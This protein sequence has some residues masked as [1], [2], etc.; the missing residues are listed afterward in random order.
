VKNSVFTTFFESLH[1]PWVAGSSP[2]FATYS[3]ANVF[4]GG[5]SGLQLV[6]SECQK[7]DRVPVLPLFA[8]PFAAVNFSLPLTQI[9]MFANISHRLIRLL[10]DMESQFNEV[11][12]FEGNFSGAS[13]VS[14][15]TSCTQLPTK[16]KMDS[17][18]RI[19]D[20]G[21]KYVVRI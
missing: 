20:T 9:P 19:C 1:K 4:I 8:T 7:T 16:L 14:H 11:R 6:H 21:S 13:D 15:E 17:G 18:S 5:T 10:A 2:V 3:F 12:R